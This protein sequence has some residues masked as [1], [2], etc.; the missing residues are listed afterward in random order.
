MTLQTGKRTPR[1]RR[2]LRDTRGSAAVEF[3]M[4]APAFFGLLFS[5]FEIGITYTA[6]ALLQDAINDTARMIRT[7]QAQGAGM[8]RQEFRDE[9]CDRID[10]LLACDQRLQIDV[11]TFNRFANAQFEDPL[12]GNGNFRD[13]FRYDPGAACSIV[14]IRGFYAWSPI[15]PGLGEFMATMSGG[16][17]LIEVTAAIRNEPYASGQSGCASLG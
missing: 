9:V 3:A 17:H 14:V 16:E 4:L 15:T 8:T 11:R 10:V 7:G 2:L 6:D 13:D 5:M 12:D 1:G